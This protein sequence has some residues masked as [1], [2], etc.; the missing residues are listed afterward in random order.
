MKPVLPFRFKT[1]PVLSERHNL[2]SKWAVS[3]GRMAETFCPHSSTSLKAS[4]IKIK[5]NANNYQSTP[6]MFT[7]IVDQLYLRYSSCKQ[8]QKKDIN[9][10]HCFPACDKTVQGRS[11]TGFGALD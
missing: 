4:S 10:L 6:T 3:A 9:R 2:E 5:N 11:R 8:L 1:L 7:L